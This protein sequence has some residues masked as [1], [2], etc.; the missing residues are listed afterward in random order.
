MGITPKVGK[1]VAMDSVTKE[2]FMSLINTEFEVRL[3]PRNKKVLVE[4]TIV[5]LPSK[6]EIAS[7]H[8]PM[9]E[10]E[11]LSAIK[12][13]QLKRDYRIIDF[14]DEVKG[15]NKGDLPLID[16]NNTLALQRVILNEN[17][18]TLIEVSA[19]L[20]GLPFSVRKEIIAANKPI[21]IKE[22]LMVEDH[23]IMGVYAED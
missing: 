8:R 2:E 4:E 5:V 16:W 12:S 14:G 11:R 3:K 1:V 9:P 6:L 21:I 17:P 15:L 7:V 13:L 22:Y 20:A 23:S 10:E 18:K 19:A